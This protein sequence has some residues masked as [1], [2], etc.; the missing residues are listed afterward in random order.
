MQYYL[1][2]FYYFAKL[3]TNKTIYYLVDYI[4]GVDNFVERLE[5]RSDTLYENY[6]KLTYEITPV[7]DNILLGTMYDCIS[8]EHLIDNEISSIVNMTKRIPNYYE[9]EFNY[10]KIE[11]QDISTASLIN[12]FDV[13]LKFISE[14][15][16]K[17]KNKKIL[18]HC[19]FGSSRSATIVLL[20]LIVKH[21]MDI[22]DAYSYLKKKRPTI[23]LNKNFYKELKQYT[24]NLL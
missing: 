16:A 15:Q 12:K 13:I 22:D 6:K 18:I 5:E 11:A 3:M 17:Y 8:Y 1:Y 24:T 4:Y 14:Q 23:N 9:S 20:Y 10:L 21:K 19:E 2:N 7:I